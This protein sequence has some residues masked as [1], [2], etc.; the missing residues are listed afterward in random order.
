MVQQSYLLGLIGEGVRPSLTPTMHEQESA[1]QN[2]S[3]VYRPIDLTELDLPASDVGR[4]L[5]NG[6]IP[7]AKRLGACNTV[8]IRNG[9]LI[10]YN[11]HRS[12]FA[13]GL[14]F[15]LPDADLED[16]VLLGAVN[17]NFAHQKSA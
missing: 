5:Q 10:G 2:L 9:K 15:V 6:V 17:A 3:F 8:L 16:V 13:S 11:T 7:A 12:G 4:L 1:A 14:D